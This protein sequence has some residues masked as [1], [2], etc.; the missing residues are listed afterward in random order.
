MLNIVAFL[1]IN[2][3]VGLEKNQDKVCNE[4]IKD[5][6]W[7]LD[8]HFNDLKEASKRTE[9]AS[10]NANKIRP[11]IEKLLLVK[12]KEEADSMSI[13]AEEM[14]D[15]LGWGFH[16]EYE[17][18]KELGISIINQFMDKFEIFDG[19]EYNTKLNIIIKN[20]IVK[21][22]SVY[23]DL[24]PVFAND[25]FDSILINGVHNTCENPFR[26]KDSVKFVLFKGKNKWNYKCLYKTK[27]NEE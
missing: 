20:Q 2:Y 14:I 25:N 11:I 12:N 18:H 1:L 4:I 13:I 15:K 21:S 24:M 27:Y 7:E 17:N 22:D 23:I 6:N 16:L 3:F 5:Y 9:I 19:K 26:Y 10:E 8:R